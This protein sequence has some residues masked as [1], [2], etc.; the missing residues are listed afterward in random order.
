MKCLCVQIGSLCAF[1]KLIIIK[2]DQKILNFNFLGTFDTFLCIFHFTFGCTYCILKLKYIRILSFFIPLNLHHR[3][4][5]TESCGVGPAT[6][7][8]ILGTAPVVSAWVF[9]RSGR[10]FLVPFPTIPLLRNTFH[11]PVSAAFELN[12]FRLQLSYNLPK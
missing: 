4:N 8:N 3:C 11:P 7:I 9:I 6:L 10:K 1:T 12:L 5:R 2:F